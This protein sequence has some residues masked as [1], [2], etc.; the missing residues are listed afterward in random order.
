MSLDSLSSPSP[1]PEPEASR[2]GPDSTNVAL[3]SDSELSDLTE[4]EQETENQ[5]N[6][7]GRDDGGYSNRVQ[8]MSRRGGAPTNRSDWGWRRRVN[9]A[10]DNAVEEEEEEEMSGPLKAMEEE[11]EDEEDDSGPSHPHSRFRENENNE[12]DED[13][14]DDV[15]NGPL[16]D[17]VDEEEYISGE[18]EPNT[19]R[20]RRRPRH[21][22]YQDD[23]RPYP[24][25]G[26]KRRTFDYEDDEDLSDPP[27]GQPDEEMDSDNN[28][29]T[30]SDDEDPKPSKA[31]VTSLSVVLPKTTKLSPTATHADLTNS[32]PHVVTP[33]AAVAAASSIM[34]GSTVID[35]PSPSS[36]GSSRSP[37]PT[38][39]GSGKASKQVDGDGVVAAKRDA[40]RKLSSAEKHAELQPVAADNLDNDKT[41]DLEL[42]EQE[43]SV[44]DLEAEEAS[45]DQDLEAELESD[46]QPAHRAEALDVLATIELKFALLRERVYVEKMEGLAWEE[47][48]I[49]E[50]AHSHFYNTI[51][52]HI[53]TIRYALGSHPELIHLQAELSKRRDKR[54]E[55]ALRKRT[56]EIA[57]VTKKRCLD[58]DA[59]WS[60]WKV[61]SFSV[62]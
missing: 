11:E 62:R 10:S 3:D 56:Y 25:S 7:R 43:G 53:L 48:L 45:P 9:Q 54:L 33:L 17:G 2:P 23:D 30:E 38:Y 39:R 35:P 42:P 29:V 5:N 1:S 20:R 50:G 12:G 51:P 19:R 37:S 58:E 22:P 24:P 57:S 8:T 31:K 49:G 46:L 40:K 59:T 41:A 36:S 21:P 52:S 18:D 6:H 14:G 4:E 60:W 44:E 13:D 16:V 55:L 26:G 32:L 61:R 15:E 34:A 28:N 27:S 47:A